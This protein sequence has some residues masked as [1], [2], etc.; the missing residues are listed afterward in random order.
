MNYH[1][2]KELLK[3]RAD[4]AYH[5]EKSG[6]SDGTKCNA[7]TRRALL[8]KLKQMAAERHYTNIAPCNNDTSLLQ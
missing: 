2:Q 5:A 7:Q 1:A 8:E 4:T 3:R 6:K